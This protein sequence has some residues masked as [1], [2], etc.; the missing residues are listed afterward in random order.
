MLQ[1]FKNNNRAGNQE[2][3]KYMKGTLIETRPMSE[4]EIF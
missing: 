4:T 3:N 2:R 1:L